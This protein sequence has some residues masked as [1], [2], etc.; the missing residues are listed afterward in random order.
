CIGN[1]VC[2]KCPKDQVLMMAGTTTEGT[3]PLADNTGDLDER[4]QHLV[5]FTK[6]FCVDTTEVTVGAFRACATAGKCAAAGDV[7]LAPNCTTTTNP[8]AQEQ[9]PVTCITWA[10]AQAFCQ[11]SGDGTVHSTGARRLLTEAEWEYQ[12]RGND[13]RIFPWGNVA[14]TCAYANF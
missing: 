10:Q 11:W 5:T 7:L 13:L 12:A 14:P 3:D 4:P 1:A 6:S 9:F 2:G 8:G